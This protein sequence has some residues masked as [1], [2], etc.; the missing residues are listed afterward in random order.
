MSLADISWKEVKSIEDIGEKMTYDVLMPRFHNL[1]V[2]DIY[3][4][5]TW[6]MVAH[7]LWA[8]FTNMGGKKKDGGT[9]CVVAVP[10]DKQANLI[11]REL[12]KQIEAN[13]ILANSVKIMKQSPYTIEF[14]NTS[15]IRI[16]TTGAKTSSGGASIRGQAAD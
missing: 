4:H 1:I 14:K 5:N 16:F 2:E 10:Y 15:E 3:V 13:D 9:I 6:T 12:R 8:A 7:M 11:Y